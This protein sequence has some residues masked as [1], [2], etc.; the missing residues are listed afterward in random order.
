MC[1]SA[2]VA[3]CCPGIR[4]KGTRNKLSEVS[5]AGLV[6]PKPLPVSRVSDNVATKIL[7]HMLSGII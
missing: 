1:L 4:C 5:I 7:T 2:A 3:V 6:Y